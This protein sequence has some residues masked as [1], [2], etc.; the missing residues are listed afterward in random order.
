MRRGEKRTWEKTIKIWRRQKVKELLSSKSWR[1]IK[2]QEK[3][4]AEKKAE[5]ERKKKEL[6][7]QQKLKKKEKNKRK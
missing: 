2:K 4:L 5:E 3:L 6:I 7:A 1:G